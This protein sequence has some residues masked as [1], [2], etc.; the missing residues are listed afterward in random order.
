MNLA[1][2]KL[3]RPVRSAPESAPSTPLGRATGGKKRDVSESTWKK[4]ESEWEE[5]NVEEW[6]NREVPEPV[7]REITRDEWM[8]ARTYMD[9]VGAMEATGATISKYRRV[10]GKVSWLAADAWEMEP[11]R[12]WGTFARGL[13]DSVT[14]VDL[15]GLRR[16]RL[17]I[18][19][20]DL[21]GPAPRTIRMLF[22]KALK[23]YERAWRAKVCRPVV[24]ELQEFLPADLVEQTPRGFHLVWVLDEAVPI[25]VAARLAAAI[26]ARLTALPDGV[27]V[28]SFPTEEGRLCALPLMGISREVGPD[29][30]THEFSRRCPALEAFLALPGHALEEFGELLN[31]PIPESPASGLRVPQEAPIEAP[32][33]H[34]E[35]TGD[36]LFGEDFAKEC[37]RLFEG[38][39]DA[40]DHYDATRRIA[41]CLFYVS[42]SVEVAEARFESWIALP[43]HR[44][45]HC[46]TDRR[47][48][49]R[50]FRCQAR[51][52]TRGV[53]AGRCYF[54]GMRS[55]WIRAYAARLDDEEALAA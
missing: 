14:R 13:C 29:L 11:G 46:L 2:P 5:W 34:R 36:Q 22:G 51:Y 20:V 15:L 44:S 17:I 28:E 25:E 7:R 38:G 52:F 50:D 16:T 26:K 32:P 48:L 31:E 37:R 49:M 41:A 42:P 21:H 54:D 27:K 55:E 43:I 4:C 1:N 53:D 19:D 9:F 3:S 12:F 23:K 40:G 10:V 18:V 35:A 30:V 47:H 45:R 24:E 33:G 6:L 8:L 39:I